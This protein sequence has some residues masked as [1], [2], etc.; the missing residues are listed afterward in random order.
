MLFLI[1]LLFLTGFPTL[2]M[3]QVD[4]KPFP[5]WIS[6]TDPTQRIDWV[7]HSSANVEIDFDHT[8][9]FI[10]VDHERISAT[11]V[12]VTLHKNHHEIKRFDFHVG[13]GVYNHIQIPESMKLKKGDCVFFIIELFPGKE[14]R[15][16][17]EMYV[18]NIFPRR[19]H[20]IKGKTQALNFEVSAGSNKNADDIISSGKLRKGKVKF[21]GAYPYRQNYRKAD[22]LNGWIALLGF[23]TGLD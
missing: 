23:L 21:K 13:E 8:I 2:L 7:L 18:Y 14:Q 1:S 12:Q 6:T 4:Y 17:D 3:A 15:Q 11:R 5:Q 22:R 16:E 20:L 19:S 9:E 10:P